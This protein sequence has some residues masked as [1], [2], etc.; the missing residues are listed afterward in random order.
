MYQLIASPFLG[1]H[2]VFRPGARQPS[3]APVMGVSLG[4]GS[5]LF[6]SPAGS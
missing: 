2:F 5:T 6:C 4:M 3:G 1:H